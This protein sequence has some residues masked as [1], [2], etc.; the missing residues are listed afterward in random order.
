M[1]NGANAAI[2]K[3]LCS[4]AAI[5]FK[6]SFVVEV[7]GYRGFSRH[8]FTKM[9]ENIKLR[10]TISSNKKVLSNNKLTNPLFLGRVKIS[11]LS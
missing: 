7:P 4:S 3:M 8:S 2:G 11:T 10:S 5:A 6:F 9:I 1:K